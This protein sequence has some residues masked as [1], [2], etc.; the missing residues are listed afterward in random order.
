MT[1]M[2]PRQASEL[3][4]L[5]VVEDAGRLGVVVAAVL[6]PLHLRLAATLHQSEKHE[7]SLLPQLHYH[8][9]DEARSKQR[10]SRSG[11]VRSS[12][13]ESVESILRILLA[14][15]KLGAGT[16]T[17]VAFTNKLGKAQ[18][19]SKFAQLEYTL[20]D[21]ERGKTIFEGIVDSHPKRWDLWSIYMDTEAG[22]GETQ[23]S[24]NIFNRVFAIKMTSHKARPS[25]KKWLELERKIGDEEVC[26]GCQAEGR[27]RVDT[28]SCIQFTMSQTWMSQMLMLINFQEKV[29]LCEIFTVPFE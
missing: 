25:L 5:A 27:S 7:A 11:P 22:R 20:G 16:Q 3:D 26:I 6:E 12:Q 10:I 29:D 21:A 18:A 28:K 14:P 13:F 9:N 4:K 1:N 24:R 17:A 8:T 15:P 19:L 2:Q 23:S